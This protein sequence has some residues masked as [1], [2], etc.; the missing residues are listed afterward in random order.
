M[1]RLEAARG[2]GL[3]VAKGFGRAFIVHDAIATTAA[4]ASQLGLGNAFH[5]IGLAFPTVALDFGGL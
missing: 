3:T 4:P 1:N 2:S 5:A